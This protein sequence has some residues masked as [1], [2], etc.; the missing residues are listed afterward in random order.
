MACVPRSGIIG[1]IF[2]I[3]N[4]VVVQVVGVLGGPSSVYWI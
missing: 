1:S 4:V 2:I 3:V